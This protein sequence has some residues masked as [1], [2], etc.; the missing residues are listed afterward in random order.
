VIAASGI[1]SAPGKD[2]TDL[3]SAGAVP[4]NPAMLA[5]ATRTSTDLDQ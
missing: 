3:G 2:L 5:A 4:A 1:A